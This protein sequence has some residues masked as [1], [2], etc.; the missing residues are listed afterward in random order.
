MK[1][2]GYA[3]AEGTRRYRDRLVAAGAAHVGHFRE[4]LGG[5]TLSTIWLG[6]YLGEHDGATD[7]LYQSAIQQP[8]KAGCNVIDSAIY[9]LC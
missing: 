9:Y 7:A 4:G 6:T 8:V 5:L 3:T 2:T 1:L